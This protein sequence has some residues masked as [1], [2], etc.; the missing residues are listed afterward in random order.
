VFIILQTA[1]FSI[2]ESIKMFAEIPDTID[3]QNGSQKHA[4]I[5]D[6]TLYLVCKG[7]K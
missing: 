3:I 1:T 7:N 6:S 5:A 2:F 4:A